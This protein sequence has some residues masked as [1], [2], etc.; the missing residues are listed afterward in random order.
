MISANKM[1]F[2]WKG[3]VRWIIRLYSRVTMCLTVCSSA[4]RMR[5][6]ARR[7]VVESRVRITWPIQ[8]NSEWT[9]F[10]WNIPIW[11][12][13]ITGELWPAI[14]AFLMNSFFSPQSWG[15]RKVD[16]W[17]SKFRFHHTQFAAAGWAFTRL[18]AGLSWSSSV[19]GLSGHS[20]E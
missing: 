7:S 3:I 17:F 13:R 16:F 4:Q 2:K 9:V 5:I 8:A 15:L 20:L 1:R 10:D 12:C 14:D 18:H 11:K 6:E 19:G